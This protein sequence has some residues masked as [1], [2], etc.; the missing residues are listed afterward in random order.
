[1]LV[2]CPQLVG[3]D[4]ELASL[5]RALAETAGHH[6]R[7]LLLTGEAGVGK[8]RLVRELVEEAAGRGVPVLSGRAV[9]TTSPSPF[10]PLTEALFSHLRRADLAERS[11]LEPFLWV[12]DRLVP[13]WVPGTRDAGHVPT[14]VVAEALLRLLRS[15]GAEA[16]C[17]LVLE[18][19]HWADPETTDVVEY[20]ADNIA[21]EPVL[22]LATMRDDEPTQT[23]RKLR[24]LSARRAVTAIEL[25]RLTGA[26]ADAMVAACLG[27]D[28][29]P[30][31]WR[32]LLTSTAE[33]LPLLVE[34]LLSAAVDPV[35]PVDGPLPDPLVPRS[36][37]ETVRRKLTAAPGTVDVLRPAALLGRSFDWDLLPAISGLTE[38]EVIDRLRDAAVRRL[39]TVEAGENA[40]R[41]RFRHALTRAAVLAELLPPERTELAARVLSAVEAAHPGLPGGWCECAAQLA[42]EAGQRTRAA[43]L[44]LEVSRRALAR[45]ALASAETGL[46][47]ARRLAGDDRD[48]TVEVDDALC[49]VLASA[50]DSARLFAVGDRLLAGL[51]ATGASPARLAAVQ[52]RLARAAVVA[53]DWTVADQHLDEADALAADGL[54]GEV[55]LLKAQLAL[56]RGQPDRAAELARRGLAEAEHRGRPDWECEAL[57]VLGRCERQ[58]SLAAAERAF[59]A[60]LGLAQE[61][62]LEVWRIRALH[63]LG[64]IDLLAGGSVDRLDEARR[65]ALDAGALSTAATVGLQMAAWYLNHVELDRT[66][67]CARTVAA[68]AH[69]LRM[70]LLESLATMLEAAAHAMR[71]A[72]QPMAAALASALALGGDIREVAGAAALQV[73]A[74]YWLVQ[75]DHERA[76][77]ELDTGMELLRGTLATT[78][79]RGM[80]ALLHAMHRQD[81]ASAL[82]EVE[83]SG[84]T[85][86]WLIRGWVQHG[87]AV[88]LGRAGNHQGAA[89]M[90]AAADATLAPCAWYRQHARRLIA[91][92]AV[93]DGWGEPQRWLTEALA[94]FDAEGYERV[95]SACRALLRRMG[96]AVPRRRRPADAPST[97]AGLGLTARELEVLALLAGGQPTKAIA[98]QLF[99]SPKTV[100][101]HIANLATKTRVRGRAELI[102][103]AARHFAPTA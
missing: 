1:M 91:E 64:T 69:R 95:A 3:R 23:V 37:T 26:E 9:D 13:G 97:V 83:E 25:H 75:E 66:V 50:G 42:D 78:P 62:G 85:G 86:Y 102:A 79:F 74:S 77:A 92:A 54:L 16:G 41:F 35:D 89:D 24:L 71:Q 81:G 15:I 5:R 98:A 99:V 61:H 11:A 2:P 58:R 12:L 43:A 93:S 39:V 70:S 20:L 67:E 65:A 19:L 29:L 90:F 46:D 47:R 80:W 60:A 49:A 44:F 55:D 52:V 45:G 82:A 87:H 30:T 38:E 21:G 84:L 14:V 34:E 57:Q 101:R 27:S 100:E 73:R 36:Y 10:R 32:A 63:E 17:L 51:T 28:V 96:A 53:A 56:G 68:E 48:L 40:A 7:A 18:D 72:R 4:D 76:L 103:F 94:F 8:S 6:G 88:L 33:G 22:C 31:Q 59:A